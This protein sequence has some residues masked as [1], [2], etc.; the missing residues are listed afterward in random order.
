MAA[1]R[2]TST[3]L[4]WRIAVIIIA[5]SALAGCG[6]GGG[7]A[8]SASLDADRCAELWNAGNKPSLE[9]DLGDPDWQS[10]AIIEVR[11][12]RCYIEV[13]AEG[14]GKRWRYSART[15]DKNPKPGD[16]WEGTSRGGEDLDGEPNA[17]WDGDTYEFVLD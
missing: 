5:A 3:P 14:R 8:K 13:Y 17:E 11:N 7:S 10:E 9:R 1:K 2:P 6:A 16:P 4:G 12:D 15:L